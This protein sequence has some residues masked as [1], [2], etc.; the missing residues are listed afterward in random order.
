M[1]MCT[2]ASLFLGYQMLIIVILGST[3]LIQEHPTICQTLGF[4]I[5]YFFLSAFCWMSAMSGEV[6]STFRQLGGSVHSDIR[7]RNQRNR[8]YYF[9]LFSWGFPGLVTIV[10][11]TMHLLPEEKTVSIVAPGFGND[12]CFLHGYATQM[13]SFHG[14]IALMLV[15]NLLFFMTSSYA[16]LFGIW[17]PSRDMDNRSRSNTRQMFGIIVEL[18]LLIGLTWLADVVYLV[19]NWYNG[20]A[21]T[22]WEIVI[23]DII[24][25]L[26]GL[27]IF[28]VLICKPRMRRTI[29]A[30]LAP[31]LKCFNHKPFDTVEGCGKGE[32]HQAALAV[33]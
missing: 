25:S 22:G 4:L 12:S 16:L 30:S 11:L 2:V 10:T 24:N 19:I 20:Q 29:R 17:A 21:H 26:Q 8:F 33:Q 1:K 28:L 3:V 27:L 31:A 6:W 23:F 32:P 5:Q 18:F 9:N 15:I 7:F 13:A 14:I